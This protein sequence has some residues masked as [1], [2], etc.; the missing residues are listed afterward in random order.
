LELISVIKASWGWS[1]IEP[2]QVVGDNDFGNLII[3]DAV[4][5]YWRLCPEDL[6]CKVV[7]Q[8]RVE[9]DALSQD[10]EFLHDWHMVKLVESARIALGTLKPG[11]KYSLKIPSAFGGEYGG[12][13][14]ATVPFRELVAAS[15]HIA[16]QIQGLPNGAQVKLSVTE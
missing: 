2:T 12:S 1:G 10:Q 14:L 5:R 13:N 6:Y 11:Y 15:G 4:G 8:N 3:K 7:A 9:L 16:E